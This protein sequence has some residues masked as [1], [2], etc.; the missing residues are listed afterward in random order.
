MALGTFTVMQLSSIFH[1]YSEMAQAEHFSLYIDSYRKVIP[2]ETN[3]D[4]K[5]LIHSYCTRKEI[6]G[7]IPAAK[8][9]PNYKKMLKLVYQS[10]RIY[11]NNELGNIER[12]MTLYPKLVHR[13]QSLSMFIGFHSLESKA[14]ATGI[15][16]ALENETKLKGLSLSNS[17]DSTKSKF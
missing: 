9:P 13:S 6:E 8:N 14:I 11:V 17:S 15:M 3:A 12:L 10:L 2:I 7:V 16:N 5:H 1:D 4:L